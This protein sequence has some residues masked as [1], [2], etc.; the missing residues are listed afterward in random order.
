M[1]L[2]LINFILNF[3]EQCDGG[4]QKTVRTIASPLQRGETRVVTGV[5]G[6]PLARQ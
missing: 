3:Q 6:L 2:L 5:T 1:S 4:V